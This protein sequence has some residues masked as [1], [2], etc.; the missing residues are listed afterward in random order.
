MIGDDEHG[1]GEDGVFNFEGG[2]YAKTIRLRQ[3]WEPLI[4]NATRHFG[5]ILENV[6]IDANTRRV[7]F[8]DASFTEN[9]RAAYP[10]GFNPNIEPSGRTGHPHTVFFLTADAFG[11]LPPI[12][13]LTPSQTLYHFLSG[14]TA[15]LAGTE[16][17]LGL[18]PQVTFSSCFG[19]PFL[20]LH[21]RV[22]A[23][24]LGEKLRQH[25]AQVWLVNTG[26]T[27]GPCGTGKRIDLPLTRALVTAA[28]R[29]E[30]RDVP[31]RSDPFFG[32][33]VPESCP[34]V[35]SGLLNPRQTWQ[36]PQEYDACAS[37]L[38]QK[39]KDN[40]TQFSGVVSDEIAYAGPK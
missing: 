12:A 14:Y 11:V 1:W 4:W 23:E 22:Y 21:P 40:F 38:V 16:K 6:F 32:F 34:G 26:W 28:L 19:A 17:G 3:D 33:A 8:D 18:E 10:I 20:P 37:A 13:R 35:P 9:T 25:S 24:M 15:K 29:G 5:C 31:M 2:C 36:D 27:G 39:F 7:N 30:L